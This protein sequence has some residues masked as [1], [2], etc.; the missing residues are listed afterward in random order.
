MPRFLFRS[1]LLS[2]S[3]HAILLAWLLLRIH[4]KPEAPPS[5][6]FV[7]LPPP[8]GGA[9]ADSQT[10]GD[11][12]SPPARTGKARGNSASA[13]GA[14]PESFHWKTRPD[15]WEVGGEGASPRANDSFGSAPARGRGRGSA[16][17]DLADGM[18]LAAETKFYNLADKIWRRVNHHVEYP[19]DFIEANVEGTVLLHIKVRPDGSFTGDFL[20]IEDDNELLRTYVMAMVAYALR[21]PIP[22]IPATELKEL[23]FALRFQFK[24]LLP[25]EIRGNRMAA[26]YKNTLQFDRVAFTEPKFTKDARQFLVNWM[27]PVIPVPG[28][29]FIDFVQLYKQLQAKQDRD[30]RWK[31]GFRMEMDQELWKG[32]IRRSGEPERGNL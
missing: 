3:L 16:V 30:P 9:G 29:F 22:G 26:H 4:S 32:L 1:I 28:G 6:L 18:D 20:E 11:V 12:T 7:D 13:K 15:A 5:A 31:R 14:K 2:L 27:P 8:G 24:L 23:A 10:A 21:E 17:T 25:D 19:V